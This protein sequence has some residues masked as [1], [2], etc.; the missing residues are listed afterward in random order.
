MPIS[1]DHWEHD[2]DSPSES[3]VRIM[4]IINN[5]EYLYLIW[6]DYKTYK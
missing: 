6:K 5:R 3:G 4:S 2:E 1:F